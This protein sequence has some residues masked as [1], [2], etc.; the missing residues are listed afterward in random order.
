MN[1][2]Q[3]SFTAHCL[4]FTAHWLYPNIR[5]I[6]LSSK[7]DTYRTTPIVRAYG[8]R[9]GPSTPTTP[10][11]SSILLLVTCAT[12]PHDIMGRWYRLTCG[13]LYNDFPC[14]YSIGQ[15]ATTHALQPLPS[16]LAALPPSVNSTPNR[17]PTA[18]AS[19]PVVEQDV[20][21]AEIVQLSVAFAA[22]FRNRTVQESLPPGAW[23][24]NARNT[25]TVPATGTGQ[26]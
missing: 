6:K 1:S 4:L 2:Q 22:F 7:P 19:V 18:T 25:V 21:A 8:I 13:L 17:S 26:R 10:F 11:A 3:F 15:F 5:P 9:C 20:A 14:E 12:A 16:V 24:T 23:L